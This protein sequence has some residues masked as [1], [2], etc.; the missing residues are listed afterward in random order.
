[1]SEPVYEALART[2]A[3]LGLGAVFGLMGEETA[4]LTVA[5]AERG[6][7]RYYSTRHESAA[8]SAAD[9]YARATGGLGV[10]LI[11][12][13]PGF[14]NALTALVAARKAGSPVL[15]LVADTAESDDPAPRRYPKH[16]EQG[17]IAAA[18]GL[19]SVRVRD[20]ARA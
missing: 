14:T 15:A 5:I 11:S 7:T 2:F 12:R 8:V 6:E 17:E 20:G 13:G 9:G 10:C 16:M 3:D 4:K 1:M 19:R 18:C